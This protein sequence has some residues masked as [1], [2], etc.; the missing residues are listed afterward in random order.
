MGINDLVFS[1]WSS[2][3]D[4]MNGFPCLL[5]RLVGKLVDEG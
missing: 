2:T 1:W 5:G 4:R 3:S